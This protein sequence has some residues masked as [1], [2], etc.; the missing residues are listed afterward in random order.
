MYSPHS[1]NACE[2]PG[3][4][5]PGERSVLRRLNKEYFAIK[6]LPYFL[7]GG[8]DTAG[9]SERKITSGSCSQ[10]AYVEKSDLQNT[11]L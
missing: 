8:A 10:G 4:C 1:R 7:E 6:W 11:G 3:V 2:G 5:V 9:G